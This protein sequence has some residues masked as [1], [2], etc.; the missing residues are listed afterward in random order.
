MN[1]RPLRPERNALANLSYTPAVLNLQYF[2]IV[3]RWFEKKIAQ[4]ETPANTLNH[5]IFP[6]IFL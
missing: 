2:E 1:R 6:L 4:I 5:S 3:A